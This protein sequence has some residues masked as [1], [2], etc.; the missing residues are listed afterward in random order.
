MALE[1]V[2]SSDGWRGYEAQS[3]RRVWETPSGGSRERPVFS[4]PAHIKSSDFFSAFPNTLKING[5]VF[6]DKWRHIRFS[7][8]G[9]PQSV[10]KKKQEETTMKI[11][12]V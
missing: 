11:T 6:F 12:T 2:I 9:F 3:R 10:N 1:S 5:F 4:G 8:I 7:L